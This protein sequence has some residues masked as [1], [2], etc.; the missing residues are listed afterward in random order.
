[1]EDLQDHLDFRSSKLFNKREPYKID[2]L[3]RKIQ[4]RESESMFN[5]ERFIKY[6]GWSCQPIGRPCGPIEA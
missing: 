6:G 1:M 4:E 3:Q 5:K 2:A